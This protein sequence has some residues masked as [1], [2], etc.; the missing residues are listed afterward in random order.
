MRDGDKGPNEDSFDKGTCTLAIAM[1]ATLPVKYIPPIP[2]GTFFPETDR[3]T[4]EVLSV[5]AQRVEQ[6]CVDG[7]AG[8][9]SR[10]DSEDFVSTLPGW[11]SAGG[12]DRRLF[13]FFVLLDIMCGTD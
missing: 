5:L 3:T 1:L 12:F 13:V 2:L 7:G 9:G 6:Q 10:R 4:Y 8:G 11:S